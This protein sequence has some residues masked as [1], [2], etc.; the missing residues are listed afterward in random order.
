LAVAG[1]AVN[2][3][4]SGAAFLVAVTTLETTKTS[5]IMK[6]KMRSGCR[7]LIGADASGCSGTVAGGF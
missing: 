1:L 3:L 5:R 4:L 7:L 2:W 6:S